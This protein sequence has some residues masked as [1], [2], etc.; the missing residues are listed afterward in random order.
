[1]KYKFLILLL[2]ILTGIVYP[3]NEF[4]KVQ[5]F[6]LVPTNTWPFVIWQHTTVLLTSEFNENNIPT[7]LNLDET[8]AAFN[9]GC[10]VWGTNSCYVFSQNN[11]GVECGFSTD[12]TIFPDP[13]NDGG[14]AKLAVEN[15]LYGTTWYDFIVE[16][17]NHPQTLTTSTQVAFNNSLFKL[18]QWTNAIVFPPGYNW[19]NF[20]SVVVHELGHLLGLNHCTETSAVMY[21][22][23]YYN[24]LYYDLTQYDITGIQTVCG[25]YPIK[26]YSK[27]F[28][29]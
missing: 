7:N 1:M 6:Q 20:E 19:T 5:N 4:Y 8:I 27:L 13:N 23:H 11:D 3:H 12:D 2:L 9:S 22:H 10:G 21:Y 29:H 14:A 28:F 16:S 17:T 15:V 18:F 25:H 24:T 26:C